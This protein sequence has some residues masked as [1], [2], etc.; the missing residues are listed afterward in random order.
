MKSILLVDDEAAMRRLVQITLGDAM[1]YRI[2][3]APDGA[4]ALDTLRQTPVDL[5]LLDVHM[6]VMDGFRTC[7]GVRELPG[8]R[9]PRVVMLTARASQAD[10]ERGRAVGADDYLCKPFSPMALLDCVDRLLGADPGAT[11]RVRR[12]A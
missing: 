3:H 9:Q 8:D 12:A 10:R 2:L 4:Q 7:E 6:P 5:V 11:A 1:R